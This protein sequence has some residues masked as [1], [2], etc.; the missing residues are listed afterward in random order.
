[1]S[2]VRHRILQSSNPASAP[3]GTWLYY[4]FLSAE[5]RLLREKKMQTLVSDRSWFLGFCFQHSWKLISSKGS[6]HMIKA[7]CCGRVVLAN[8]IRHACSR[9]EGLTSM[10][11]AAAVGQVQLFFRAVQ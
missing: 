1:M 6:L 4:I 8:G 9:L 2:L 11:C 3:D 10:K 7:S 5:G